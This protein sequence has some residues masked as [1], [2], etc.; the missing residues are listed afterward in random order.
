MAGRSQQGKCDKHA[1]CGNQ[2][3]NA[4]GGRHVGRAG[5]MAESAAIT[6]LATLMGAAPIFAALIFRP[7]LVHGTVFI[8]RGR[9]RFDR[10]F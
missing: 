10:L 8:R 5:Q 1:G 4:H 6:G 7:R 2:P 3:G 9:R